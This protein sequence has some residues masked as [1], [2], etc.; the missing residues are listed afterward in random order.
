MC[1]T[2]QYLARGICIAWL[3]EVHPRTFVRDRTQ[4]VDCSASLPSTAARGSAI[5]YA[6]TFAQVTSGTCSYYRLEEA[7][8]V[9]D[10]LD[11]A[12]AW[13][14]GRRSF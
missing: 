7:R 10:D 9:S 11:A 12:V 6:C 2:L 5:E 14:R 3:D 4:F 1:F 8:L 13:L